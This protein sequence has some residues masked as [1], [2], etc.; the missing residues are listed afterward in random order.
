LSDAEAVVAPETFVWPVLAVARS[1]TSKALTVDDQQVT[2]AHQGTV[3]HRDRR[4]RGAGDDRARVPAG[5]VVRCEAP[6]ARDRDGTLAGSP[7]R[8]NTAVLL[9][10]SSMYSAGQPG[11]R[12]TGS[13]KNLAGRD[14]HAARD[15]GCQGDQV[16]LV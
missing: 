12:L 14:G 8:R 7:R 10:S 11:R 4:G 13:R 6:G 5:S 3:R 15:Q 2:Y 1:V 9:R 16:V